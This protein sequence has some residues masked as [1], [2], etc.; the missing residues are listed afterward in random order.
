MKKLI[1]DEK[2]H[3]ITVYAEDK[4]GLMAQLLMLLNRRD[5]PVLSLNV[6]RTDV[7][8]LILITMEVILPQNE[9]TAILRKM[10]RIIEVYKAIGYQENDMPLS[11]VGIYRVA[12]E[13]LDA[14]LWTLLQKYGAT[15]SGM[16]ENSFLIQKTGSEK[17]LSALYEA[18]EG[19]HLLAFCKS[20][21]M[22]PESLSDDILN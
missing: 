22:S 6:A 12:S 8:E 11:R 3:V 16:A 19:P 7:N 17:D 21:L 10:E 1:R 20:S 14:A 9:L 18:L 4:K 2:L 15:L 13:R 5:Y